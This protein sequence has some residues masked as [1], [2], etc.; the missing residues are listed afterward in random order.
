MSMTA[1]GTPASATTT[2]AAG[3][4]TIS[5]LPAGEYRLAVVDPS[6]ERRWEYF[7]DAGSWPDVDRV[8]VTAGTGATRRGARRRPDPP[9]SRPTLEW[10]RRCPARDELPGRNRQ[11]D[12]APDARSPTSRTP[13]PLRTRTYARRT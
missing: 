12:M 1:G 6:G 4:F 10:H 8:T 2:D 3:H 9:A 11:P 13:T 7:D 5:G